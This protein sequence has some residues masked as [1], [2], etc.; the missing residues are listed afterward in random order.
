MLR[1]AAVLLMALSGGR[2]TEY[3]R[4]LALMDVLWSR[5][6]SALAAACFVEESLEA[7][8]SVLARRQRTDVRAHTVD[9]FSDMYTCLPLCFT[10]G[11]K[12]RVPQNFFPRFEEISKHGT[13]NVRSCMI[14]A[15][16]SGSIGATSTAPRELCKPGISRLFHHRLVL[17]V[18]EML[19]SI[20]RGGLPR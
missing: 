8:L 19:Q 13:C 15:D 3:I 2:A 4:N 20:R 7:S 14:E 6:H 11:E 18:Q 16:T 5:L 17:R 9:E 1:D 12:G 10:C